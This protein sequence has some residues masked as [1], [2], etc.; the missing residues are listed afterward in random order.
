MKAEDMT[1]EQLIEELAIVRQEVGEIADRLN[2][3]LTAVLLNV[4]KRSMLVCIRF[5]RTLLGSILA[6]AIGVPP[7]SCGRHMIVSSTV[8]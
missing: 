8:R 2:N 5:W 7:K 6:M 1:K 4:T 3:V